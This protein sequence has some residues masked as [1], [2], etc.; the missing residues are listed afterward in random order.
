VTD[1]HSG[2]PV[3]GV[4]LFIREPMTGTTTDAA[5]FY[6]L[7]LPAGRYELLIQGVGIKDA[8]R[9]LLIYASGQLDIELDEQAYSLDEVIINSERL[10]QTRT[11]AIG[12]ERLAMRD[13]RNIPT[14]L[15]EVDIMK[16]VLSLPGVK[17]VGEASG[18]FNVH[19]GAT[20]QNLILFN[21]GTVYNPTH[22][23]GLFSAFNP[24][25]IRDMEL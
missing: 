3:A 20:D 7:E 19:G 18:G 13:I 10:A 23:F 1:F 9:Q 8:R 14:A 2:E 17:S 22:L 12:L 11:T 6:T 21:G 15:G 5:G 16:V 4:A 25:V 24:D